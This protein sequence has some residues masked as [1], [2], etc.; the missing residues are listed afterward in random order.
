[1]VA[2]RAGSGGRVRRRSDPPPVPSPARRRRSTEVRI[3]AGAPALQGVGE[4]VRA[5]HDRWD[6]TGSAT[7]RTAAAIP[8]AARII[9]VCD[10]Y[11]EMTSDRP[12][13]RAISPHRA[14]AELFRCAEAELDP[15]VVRA[16]IRVQ[17]ERWPIPPA[18]PIA[19]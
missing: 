8:L 16:L 19:V 12:D 14:I 3:L 11:S 6:G 17:D 18:Q 4:I 9:A 10:A 5:T 2:I 1:M 13:R 15:E 7:S